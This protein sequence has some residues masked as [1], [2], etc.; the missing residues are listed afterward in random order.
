MGIQSEI[1]TFEKDKDFTEI[2]DNFLEFFCKSEEE[3]YLRIFLDSD[4]ISE[5]LA[6][7]DILS[8]STNTNY[9]WRRAVH[10]IPVPEE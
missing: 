6:P 4:P 7:L 1:K 10:N 5:T 3:P 8:G 9:S 2:E